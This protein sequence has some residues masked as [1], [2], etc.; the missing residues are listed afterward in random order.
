MTDSLIP[1]APQDQGMGRN[2][3]DEALLHAVRRE[4]WAIELALIGGI[5]RRKARIRRLERRKADVE[6]AIRQIVWKEL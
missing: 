1:K 3:D 2:E 6:A 4:W 5:E